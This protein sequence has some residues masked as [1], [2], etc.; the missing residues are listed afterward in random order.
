MLLVIPAAIGAGPAV[1]AR[2]PALARVGR[3]CGRWWPSRWR[4]WGSPGWSPRSTPAFVARYFAPGHRRD[5]AA[6]RL[7]LRPRRAA[8]PGGDG[9]RRRLPG[10][11]Q[12]LHAAVQVRHARRRRRDEPVPAARR[13]GRRG[14]ARGDPAGLVLPPRRAAA[15]PT[16]RARS[17]DPRYMDW[18]KALHA[19]DQHQPAG[20]A[21]ADRQRAAP[22][23]APAVRPPAHRGRPELAGAVDG[24]GAPALGP[25]GRSC[26]RTTS[27]RGVL[28]PVAVAPHYYRGACCVG[29][30][31]VLYQK[32]S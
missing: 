20:D 21:D 5:P 16:P 12:L 6:H 22:G 4:R 30:S 7:G 10:Q 19:A 9:A 28:R 1:H 24:D 32:V 25:V 13:P 14:P 29:N 18:V 26:C 2:A 3:W 27:T 8:G 11:P 23:P 17:S 31:A 15:T